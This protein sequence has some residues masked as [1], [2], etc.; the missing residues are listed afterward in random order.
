MW[1]RFWTRAIDPKP[2]KNNIDFLYK[3][4]FLSAFPSYNRL[5]MVGSV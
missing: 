2:D 4:G 1:Y 5:D 3:S